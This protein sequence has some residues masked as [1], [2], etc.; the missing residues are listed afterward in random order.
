MPFDGLVT[1]KIC[2]EFNNILLNG[3][4]DKIIEPTK[5]D[6]IIFI[7]N[8][9]TTYKLLLCINAQNARTCIT[10]ESNL[11]N[12]AKPFNFCMVLRKYLI[13]SKLISI[14]QIENDRILN[15]EFETNNEL[16]DKEIKILIIEMMG[17]YSNLILVTPKGAIVDSAKHIDFEMSSV[18]EVMPGRQYIL[19]LTHG[20]LNP[21]SVSDKQFYEIIK[22]NHSL[23]EN[24]SGISSLLNEKE[25]LYNFTAFS[26]FIH[27][28]NRP[29]LIYDNDELKDF[30]FTNITEK[31]IKSCNSVSDAV[32]LF[33]SHKISRQKINNKKNNLLSVVNS[34]I[35]KVKKKLNIANE[36]LKTT[37][38]MEELKKQG[39]LLQANLYKVEPY[40]KSITVED[41]YNECKPFTIT[42]DSNLSASQNIQKIF[43]K[44][45]KLKNTKIA[46]SY[47]KEQLETELIY[48]ESLSFEIQAQTSLESLDDVEEEL[49]AE[50]FIKIPKIKKPQIKSTYLQFSY[51]GFNIYVGKNN[52]QNDKLTFSVAHKSDIWFHVKNA[53]GSHTILITNNQPVTDDVIA[54]TASLAAF[55][56]KLSASPKVEIDYT[57][58]KNVKKIPGA[59]PGMVIYENYKTI[60]VKPKANNEEKYE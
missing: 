15:F 9:R 35:A 26:D 21:F 17:K 8:N 58:V 23:S 22:N 20:K 3:K 57:E 36:K 50:G 49:V 30:Y 52:I 7:R 34:S 43:K 59:K 44:Y 2:E 10:N 24:F 25:E 32:D 31:N 1:R 4:V 29:G 11:T 54:F 19:P 18:R 12:P 13:G 47:Q 45:N 14:S 41:Y 56:S 38:D 42:L 39:E 16:G 48:L 40:S 55:Y 60:Y 27:T 28:Q 5:D 33:F 51:K 37:N 6:V 53:P 46:C